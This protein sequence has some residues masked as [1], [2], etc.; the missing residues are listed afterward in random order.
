MAIDPIHS[1]YRRL[2]WSLL[3]RGLLGIALGAL[4]IWRPMDSISAFALVIALWALFTGIVQI[5]H[6]FDLRALLDHWWLMLLSGLISTVFGV[7]ALYY[8]PGLSLT[9]AIVWTAW[10]LFLTGFFSIY[11]AVQERRVQM[12]WGGTLVFGILSVLVGVLCFVS[13]PVTLAAIMGLIAGFAIVSGGMLLFG[14]YKLS[15]TKAELIS[16]IHPATAS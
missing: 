16:H 5:V 3:L 2:W 1:V 10:W 11:I 4:I 14:A 6:A 9:F 8:Y 7:A 13:P 12:P 15:S